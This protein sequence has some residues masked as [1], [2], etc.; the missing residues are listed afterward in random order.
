MKKVK[1]IIG[2]FALI[3][4]LLF[5]GC[6]METEEF[7][8]EENYFKFKSGTVVSGIDISDMTE[9]EAMPL[10]KQREADIISSY[11]CNLTFEDESFKIESTDITL[12]SNLNKVIMQAKE[13]ASDYRIE[14]LPTDNEILNSKLDEIANKINRKPVPKKIKL[15]GESNTDEHFEITNGSPGRRMDIEVVKKKMLSG[16]REI[17]ISV[18]EI[19]ESSP[20]PQ[21]PVLRS[22]SITTFNR[23]NENR[24]HN[25]ELAVLK[26]NGTILSE[27]ES[28]SFDKLLGSRTK[29]NGWLKAEAYINGGLDSEEQYGGGICQVSTNLYIAALK[30]GLDVPMRCNHSK[31]VT[32]VPA[33]LDAAISEGGMDLI[34]KNTSG[35]AVYIFSRLEE[36]KL[37][38]EIYGDRFDEEYDKIELE[39]KFMGSIQPEADEF[40][41]DYEL[42]LGEII[43]VSPPVV[44]SRYETYLVYYSE[45]KEVSRKKLN[46][47]QYK[48][49]PAIYAVGKREW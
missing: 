5:S 8:P 15:I 45:G 32:Y 1:E 18:N 13:S 6:N 30:A 40:Y 4:L 42:S 28:I 14:V 19:T 38:C 11:C 29:E 21:I 7:S 3:I 22:K 12:V 39:S 10:L 49:H 48:S 24:V 27:G 47:T 33:G 2:F 36:D 34:I 44:G 35:N 26:L 31:P 20:E 23:Y 17:D 25:L 43:L 16:V 41:D 9:S 46:E 37:I